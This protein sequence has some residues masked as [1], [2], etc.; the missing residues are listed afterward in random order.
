MIQEDTELKASIPFG[1]NN[2]EN[3]NMYESLSNALN[4]VNTSISDFEIEETEKNNEVIIANSDVRNYTYSFMDA[5][6]ISDKIQK[7][8]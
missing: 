7:C 6:S 5:N 3:F 1:V 2:D 8:I 4:N